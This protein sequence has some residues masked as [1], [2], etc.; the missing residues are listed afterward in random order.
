MRVLETH[1]KIGRLAKVLLY[2][3]QHLDE[4]LSVTKLADISQWSKAHFQRQFSAFIGVSVHQYV[5]MMR[6]RQATYQLRYRQNQSITDI[7]FDAGFEAPESL[8]RICRDVLEKPPRALRDN[9]SIDQF[10]NL[11]SQMT[12]IARRKQKLLG[13]AFGDEAISIRQ[14]P[15]TKVAQ[16][17]HQGDSRLFH[18]NLRNFIVW[19]R[20][21]GC[22]PP[23]SATYNIFPSPIAA[24]E[25][26]GFTL[27]LCA[28]TDQC[29][30]E[31]QFGI[32]PH[33][34][35]AS[36]CAVLQVVADDTHLN[37]AMRHVVHEWLPA[38]G[39]RQADIPPFIKRLSL[40]PDVPANLATSEIYVP[41][42]S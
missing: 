7:A 20:Q 10:H 42:E 25:T 33:T 9:E 5:R 17:L 18:Q 11:L 39:H 13:R 1:N 31:N 34:M 38:N 16:L 14:F 19:R 30:E 41:V 27:A 29:I 40:Y 36:S 2:I 28:E 6:L 23:K 3:D 32:V 4:E 22:T 26:M 35:P 12:D 24:N 15:K 8:A 37:A 21:A